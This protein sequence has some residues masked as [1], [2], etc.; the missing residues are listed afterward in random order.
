M[1]GRASGLPDALVGLAPDLRRALRLSLDDR[2]QST[3]ETLAV[4][5]V[6]QDRV[7][8]RTEYVVLALVEGAITDTHRPRA[9]VTSQVVAGR[10]GQVAPAVDAVHDLQRTVLGR[11]HI[12]D[13][14]HELVGLPRPG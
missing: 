10:L 14:L 8:R 9:R 2:P 5:R 13:E 12:G 1:L 11:L 4:A 6:E 7:Q 3:G